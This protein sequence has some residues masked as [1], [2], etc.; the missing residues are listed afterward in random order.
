MR[1]RGGFTLIGVVI[2]TVV[3]CLVAVAMV[4]QFS[5]AAFDGRIAALCDNLQEVRR[6]IEVY[7]RHHEGRMPASAGET[8]DDFVRRLTEAAD[9]D[10]MSPEAVLRLERMPTNPFNDFNTVR[11]GGAPA[12]AGTH[13]WRFDPLTGDFQADDRCDADADGTP[14]HARL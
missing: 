3:L 11:I 5:S 1:V 9:S 2:V 13:G 4:P 10:P 14:E 12:G 7:R 8:G 6:H